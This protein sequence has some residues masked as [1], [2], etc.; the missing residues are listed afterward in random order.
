MFRRHERMDNTV[1]DGGPRVKAPQTLQRS[2][3]HT[4]LAKIA[5]TDMAARM[6]G[7]DS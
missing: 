4:S 5:A 6:S 3:A 1:E 2:L 7:V